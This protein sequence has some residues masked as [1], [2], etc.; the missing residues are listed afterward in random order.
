MLIIILLLVGGL[1]ALT[2]GAELLVRGASRLAALA[3][4]SPLVIGLTVVAFGTSAPELTVSTIS[5]FK[6]ESEIALGNVVG[7]NIFNVLFILG[8][9]A[10]IVPLSVQTQLLRFDVPLLIGVSIFTWILGFDGRIGTIDGA[11]L[12][13][14]L[15]AY[16]IWSIRASR[17]ESAAAQAEF[18]R[19][20]NS[21]A[22]GA[23]REPTHSLSV[24]LL[25]TA[26]G[27]GLLVAGS[28]WFVEGAIEVATL[29]GMSDLVIGLTI[30]AG[31]TSLP[32]VFTSIV[33]AIKGERDI[34]V[35]N[36]IG[37]NLFNLLC[38]LGMS[39]FASGIMG[40]GGI[41]IP[42]SALRFDLIVMTAA[43]I[44]CLPIFFTGHVISRW[45]GGLL[46]AYQIIY[47]TLLVVAETAQPTLNTLEYAVLVFAVPLTVVILIV[48]VYR[49]MRRRPE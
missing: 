24:S 25:L 2:I 41:S 43:A 30:V 31:G 15:T 49:Q 17:R 35:G 46:L 16:T 3:R 33:A 14:G 26:A 9:S 37:S 48:D 12:V 39:G 1:V 18:A 32:E 4:I 23:A 11:I 8:I 6:G 36:V 5:A 44:A 34:A 29:L 19:E 42:D 10:L 40:Y 22:T 28:N 13:A 47:T 27:L 38:V 45:E 7:S 20:Y 21:G